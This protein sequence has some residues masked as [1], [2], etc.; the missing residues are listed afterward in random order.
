MSMMA[1]D[2]LTNEQARKTLAEILN[3]SEFSQARMLQQFEEY[4]RKVFSHQPYWAQWHIGLDGR[5]TL[6]LIVL[7]G[8][9]LIIYLLRKV[10]PFWKIVVGDAKNEEILHPAFSRSTSHDFLLAAEEKAGQGD[11][12]GALRGIYISALLEMNDRQLICYDPTKTNSEYL[13][14]VEEK[15]SGL[16]EPFKSLVK[17]FECKWYGLEQCGR[18][19]FQK[20]KALFA[21]LLK[22][23]AHG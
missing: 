3:T 19:D 20:G 8:I 18:E 21:V 4:L 15:A 13:R 16:R 12:R 17:L 14:E 10:F 1:A 6:W 11:F 22:D 7:A 9:V 2:I 23:G 5:L